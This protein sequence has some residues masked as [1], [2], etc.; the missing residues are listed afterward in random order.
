MNLGFFKNFKGADSV[1]LEGSPEEI[2]ELANR[3]KEFA[4]S[5]AERFQIDGTTRVSESHNAKLF[6]SLN[7]KDNDSEFQL[8]CTGDDAE[9]IQEKLLALVSPTSGHQYFDLYNS[10]VQLVVSVG[11]YGSAW[12]EKHG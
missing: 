11:E 6:A 4:H 3:V 9:I 2:S 7:P 8:K 12:W 1:L 10:K 5:G